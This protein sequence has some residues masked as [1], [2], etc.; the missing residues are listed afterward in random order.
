LGIALLL[1][2]LASIA[3]WSAVIAIA[4]NAYIGTGL[5][6]ALLVFYRSRLIKGA[7]LVP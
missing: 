1:V 2:Q 7:D 4:I 5:S 3:L 6:M